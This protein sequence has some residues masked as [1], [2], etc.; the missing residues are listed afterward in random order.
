MDIQIRPIE[1]LFCFGYD[2]PECKTCSNRHTWERIRT[3]N[4]RDRHGYGGIDFTQ[5]DLTA[6]THRVEAAA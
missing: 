3:L 1:T 2:K 6:A 4:V 5:C